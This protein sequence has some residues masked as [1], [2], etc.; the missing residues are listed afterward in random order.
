MARLTKHARS[1]I[2]ERGLDVDEVEDLAEFAH[3]NGLVGRVA[4]GGTV[5]VIDHGM[6]KTAWP[7]HP[8]SKKF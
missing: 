1:R 8:K 4:R 7:V 3:T 2:A 6:V 5:I